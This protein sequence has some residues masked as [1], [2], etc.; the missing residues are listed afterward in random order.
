MTP[1]FSRFLF[2]FAGP[3][4]WVVIGINVLAGTMPVSPFVGS[5]LCALIAFTLAC[6]SE[7]SRIDTKMRRE[8]FDLLNLRRAMVDE[9]V[10]LVQDQNEVLTEQNQRLKAYRDY[11][12]FEIEVEE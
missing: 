1:Q 7:F 8:L 2:S 12:G 10:E 6:Q 3:A 4:F 9:L 11:Y 5:G